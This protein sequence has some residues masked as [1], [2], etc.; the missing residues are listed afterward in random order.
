[1]FRSALVALVAV[2]ALGAV[3]ATA[4]QAAE[5]PFWKI[6]GAR[7]GA[8]ESQ[9]LKAK[10]R[11]AYTMTLNQYRISIRCTQQ[12][13]NAGSAISGSAGS[14][15]GSGEE[16][17]VFENCSLQGQGAGCEVYSERE[18]KKEYKVL[19]T[20]TLKQ[21]LV[22]QNK[23]RTG[24]ILVLLS[25]VLGSVFTKIKFAGTECNP[26]KEG[27]EDAIE[28]SVAAVA[29]S[30]NKAVEVGKESAEVVTN[31]IEF[32]ET[33]VQQLWTEKGGKLEEKKPILKVFGSKFNIFGTSELTLAG[34]SKWGV[35]TK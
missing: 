21:E 31:E 17:I 19:T 24:K 27:G 32:P 13:L 12:K 4:A 1:M 10:V 8:G 20:K 22:Y 35:F 9:E 15:A 23:E 18:G 26:T 7:L 25:P 29:L 14:N 30:G 3:A 2:L 33:V 34:E 11:R 28:G 5:G 6:T 16:V